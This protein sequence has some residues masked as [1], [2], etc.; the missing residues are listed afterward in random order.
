MQEQKT[1]LSSIL[2]LLFCVVGS[3]ILVTLSMP[4]FIDWYASPFMPQ[5]VSCAPSIQ[6]AINKMLWFQM[7][8][9]VMGTVFG[10]L[11]IFKFRQKSSN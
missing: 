7:A 2:I 4:K 6:W 8:S 11:F 9:V 10:V 5:G 3:F 1:I